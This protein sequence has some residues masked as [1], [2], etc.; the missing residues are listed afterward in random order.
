MIKYVFPIRI[1][2]FG[3][4]FVLLYK[5]LCV[6]MNLGSIITVNKRIFS[7]LII[8]YRCNTFLVLTTLNVHVIYLDNPLIFKQET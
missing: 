1:I 4:N 3:V 2:G 8:T 5:K 7:L 6:G